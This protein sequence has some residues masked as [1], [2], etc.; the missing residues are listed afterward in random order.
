MAFVDLWMS[1]ASVSG[2]ISGAVLQN[3]TQT[4][5]NE[6]KVL[7]RETELH[8]FRNQHHQGKIIHFEVGPFYSL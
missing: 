2:L 5:F 8:L 7:A 3:K 6:L 1:Y 4:I